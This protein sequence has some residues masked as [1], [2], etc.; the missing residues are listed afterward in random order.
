MGFQAMSECI[1]TCRGILLKCKSVERYCATVGSL[2]ALW[3][4]LA[5][6]KHVYVQV[7]LGLLLAHSKLM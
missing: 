1:C 7:N 5:L 6:Q 3:L 2:L 4:P